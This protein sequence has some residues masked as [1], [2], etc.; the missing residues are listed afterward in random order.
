MTLQQP[1][2]CKVLI[3]CEIREQY[4]FPLIHTL[5]GSFLLLRRG[6]LHNAN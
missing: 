3:P 5:D 2:L 6:R 4:K 1:T